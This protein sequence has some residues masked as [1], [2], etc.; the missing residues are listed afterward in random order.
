MIPLAGFVHDP[1]EG[2]QLF[3]RDHAVAG[4]CTNLHA[5]ANGGTDIVAGL[6][7]ETGK[8]L[9]LC[10]SFQI[11]AEHILGL[12]VIKAAVLLL[13]EFQGSHQLPEGRIGAGLIRIQHQFQRPHLF[14]QLL[15][16][17][18]ELAHHRRIIAVANRPA[19]RVHQ[20]KSQR[21][22]PDQHG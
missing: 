4:I 17:F 18:K 6:L 15:C 7:M 2:S 5:L 12:H 3:I 21:Q 19:G 9:I 1:A 20:G 14:C 8:D 13:P 16:R 11:Q 22:R 10:L